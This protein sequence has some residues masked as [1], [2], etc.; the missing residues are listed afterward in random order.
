MRHWL[1]ALFAA[2][3]V[4]AA[5]VPSALLVWSWCHEGG[6]PD[7]WHYRRRIDG[8]AEP[9]GVLP[10]RVL[11]PTSSLRIRKRRGVIEVQVRA[12]DDGQVGP[13]SEWSEPWRWDGAA[14]R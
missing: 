4:L 1:I 12:I 6:W 8:V 7:G 11:G 10:G 9:D 14:S 13:W 3:L 2:P 5:D